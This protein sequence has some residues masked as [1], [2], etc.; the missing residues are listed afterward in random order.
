MFPTAEAGAGDDAARVLTP[1]PGVEEVA[2]ALHATPGSAR[3]RVDSGSRLLEHAPVPAATTAAGLA[4]RFDPQRLAG[5][6]AGLAWVYQRWLGVVP[7]AVRGPL[8]LR[9]PTID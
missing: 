9:D 3:W 4:R 2:V 5:I 7:A 6:E 8:V 1:R